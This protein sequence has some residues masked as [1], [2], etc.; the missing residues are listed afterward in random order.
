MSLGDV[1]LATSQAQKKAERKVTMQEEKEEEKDNPL[2][3]ITRRKWKEELGKGRGHN[4]HSDRFLPPVVFCGGSD[5][6][7]SDG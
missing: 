5:P 1:H 3:I 4:K 2:F 7:R 6:R